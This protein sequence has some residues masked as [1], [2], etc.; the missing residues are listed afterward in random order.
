MVLKV[1]RAKG[2]VSLGLKQMKP[3]PWD[4]VDAKYPVGARVQGRVTQLAEFGVRRSVADA[5]AALAPILAAQL[6]ARP[7]ADRGR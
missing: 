7:A 1:D 3:N 4:T 2:K 6:A 5:G